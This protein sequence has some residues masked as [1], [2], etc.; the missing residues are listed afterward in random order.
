MEAAAKGAGPAAP[1][2]EKLPLKKEAEQPFPR[3]AGGTPTEPGASEKAVAAAGEAA[4]PAPPQSELPSGVVGVVEKPSG[5]L[6]RYNPNQ[7]QWEQ[8]TTETPLK[9]QD[10]LLSLEPFRSTLVLGGAR[11]DL[12]GETEVWVLAAQPMQAARLN[13]VQG[14][15][16]LHGTLPAAPFAIQLSGR[17]FEVTPPAN[18]AV[19]L[20]RVNRRETGS[21][22]AAS[23][24]LVVFAPEGEVAL[25]AGSVKETLAG[26]GA[27]TLQA[28]SWVNKGAKPAPSWVTETKPTPLDQQIGEQFA[29]YFRPER[30]VIANLAEA[31]DDEQKDV[32]RLAIAALRPAGD[33]SMIVP[34]LSTPDHPPRRKAAINVL[35]AFLAQGPDALQDLRE[36]L[37][38]SY[39]PD[40]AAPVEK[41]LIGY[42][43]TEAREDET[44]TNLVQQLSNED[45]GVRELALDNLRSLTGR[46][47]LNYDPDKPLGPGLKA[48]KDLLRD[49]ELRPVAARKVE[50]S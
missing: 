39:G 36:Q 22:T 38:N 30:P 1:A 25:A 32:S 10:R 42:T 35:R 3:L 24:D 45:V 21:S 11:V 13:L 31:M 15:V 4:K 18:V 7:R 16:V 20:E 44:Y 9:D 14:R 29:K 12:V 33:I 19:G 27:I 50:K 41:L 17:R 40:L 2:V 46:D 47:E 5:I 43:S 23:S 28:G 8:L 34:I 6:L 49:H 26:P 37:W 48:W